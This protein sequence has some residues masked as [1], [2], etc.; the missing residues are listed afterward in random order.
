MRSFYVHAIGHTTIR[1]R[2]R[3]LVVISALLEYYFVFLGKR[4]NEVVVD[5]RVVR[6]ATSRT[7]PMTKSST[8]DRIP[9]ASIVF[10]L[11]G[12]DVCTG[13]S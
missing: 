9:L 11:A 8:S 13:F 2:G 5:E 10:F 1:V 3:H 6:E 4:E 7:S 12:G